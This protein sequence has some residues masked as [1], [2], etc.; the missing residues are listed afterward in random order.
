MDSLFHVLEAQQFS[1]DVM[2]EIF[3]VTREME[4]VV[5]RYGSNILNRRIM[6]TLFYEPSTRT[7]LSFEAAMYRLGGEV[8][9]TESAREFSS[10]A[11]GETLEDTIRIVEGYSDVIVLRHYEGGSARRAADAASVP[12]INAGD[13]PGQHPTQA[14]LDVYTIQKE[15]GRLDGIHVALVGDLANGRTARS[16][17]Y[18]LTKYEGVKLYFVAPTV[19][20]M[21]DDIKGYLTEHGVVF[22]E[23]ED[24]MSVMSKVDVVYQTRIQRERFGDRIEDY[25]RA[26]G[27]YIIDV[28]TMSALSENAIVMH[29]LP[30]V[31]EIDPAVDTD[32]RAAY[33]RQAHNGVFIRMALLQMV[34]GV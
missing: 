3:D 19:V 15:I 28:E 11:K 20:R 1:R 34:L 33:F 26:R 4:H 29:P 7:R 31:D 5:S 6:A 13:G 18:L 22:E 9:T 14:L 10:A 17:A 12:I 24:L 8:I 21:R 25:E 23:E 16:L 2:N 27:R 32:P 30:R